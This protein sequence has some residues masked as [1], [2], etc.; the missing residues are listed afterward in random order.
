MATME[1]SP[2]PNGP[3]T[4]TKNHQNVGIFTVWFVDSVTRPRARFREQRELPVIE[5]ERM[6][7][8]RPDLENLCRHGTGGIL[9]AER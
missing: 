4:L 6:T 1:L 3:R 2:H 7:E 8:T 9:G 5:K